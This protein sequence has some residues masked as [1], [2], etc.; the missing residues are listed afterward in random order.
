MHK[1]WVAAL[2]AGTLIATSSVAFAHGHHEGNGAGHSA[3]AVMRLATGA[4]V[5]G[6]ADE[7]AKAA[8]GT[9]AVGTVTA[10]ASGSFSLQETTPSG[11][12]TLVVSYGASTVLRPAAA[13][14][15]I[16]EHVAV[17]GSMTN[18]ELAAT[19]I[20]VGSGQPETRPAG[21]VQPVHGTL[22]APVTLT[23]Q[24]AKGTQ[25][26]TLAAGTKVEVNP[27]GLHLNV[28]ASSSDQGQTGGN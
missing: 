27:G 3:A 9:T 28:Q 16:G 2:A 4:E 5:S 26:V 17:R 10:V 11:T 25:S 20:E 1:A 13:T 12:Q 24:T 8:D 23:V 7:P 22:A 18:G 15:A 14:I 21:R 6:T 19:S